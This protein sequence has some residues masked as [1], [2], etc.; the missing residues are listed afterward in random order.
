MQ[1]N[2]SEMK[3]DLSLLMIR[4]FIGG[5]MLFSHGLP[6]LMSYSEKANMFPDPIGVGPQMSLVLAIF[7]E[8]FCSIAIILGLFTRLATLPL[9]TT[10]LV[11]VVIVHG[12]DPWMKKEFG[13]LYLIFFL[14][15]LISGP[16]RWSVDAQR[17]AK[18]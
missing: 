1:E 15:L 16:G 11:A 9:I 14:V 4:V 10:M 7:A 6:K 17:Q 18:K 8:F 13:L 3:N 5:M 12:A 2:K